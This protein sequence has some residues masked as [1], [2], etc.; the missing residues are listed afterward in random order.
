MLEPGTVKARIFLGSYVNHQQLIKQELLQFI[1]IGN[2][3]GRV[4]LKWILESRQ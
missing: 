1:D 4:R 2:R 3:Y